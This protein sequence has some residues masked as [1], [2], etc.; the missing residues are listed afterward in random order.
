MKTY[1]VNLQ[2]TVGSDPDPHLATA[3]AIRAEIE[4]W[5]A[6]LG[7]DVSMVT[8]TEVGE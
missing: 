1:T 5:L 2:I 6:D 8:V 7:A 4:S 3:D